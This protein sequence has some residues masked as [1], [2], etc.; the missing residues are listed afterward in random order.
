MD[1]LKQGQADSA[2]HESTLGAPDGDPR[3]ILRIQHHLLVTQ[4]FHRGAG[5]FGAIAA[6]SLI[7]T[8]LIHFGAGITFVG[9]LGFTKI[10][11][12]VAAGLAAS[13]GPGVIV[14]AIVVNLLAAGLFWA[15]GDA[16]RR[17]K[18]WAFKLG[19]GLYVLDGVLC[20]AIGDWLEVAFHAFLL[21]GLWEGLKAS[22]QLEALT[23]HDPGAPGTP[24]PPA[25]PE[26]GLA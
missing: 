9:V 1:P 11:D 12:F 14:A 23:V 13:L 20:A 26:E 5:Q 7:N 19:M 3:Q 16:A 21:L 4:Q 17:H 25:T 15:L 10:I 8:A 18:R 24:P 2:S 22:H 6:F